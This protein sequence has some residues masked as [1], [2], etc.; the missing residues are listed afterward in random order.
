MKLLQEDR[1]R[2][3]NIKQRIASRHGHLSNDAAADV[4]DQIMSAE[5]QHLY[6]GHLS[7]DCNRPDVACHVVSERLEKIGADHVRVETTSQ[8]AISPTLTLE[9]GRIAAG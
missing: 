7:R 5:L 2:P 4:T 9:A 6:L 1:R 3:W 8:E